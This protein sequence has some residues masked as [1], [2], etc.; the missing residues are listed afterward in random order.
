ML[1]GDCAAAVATLQARG[2][3]PIDLLFIDHLKSLYVPDFVR[4]R[5]A[6]LLAKVGW[7]SF[8]PAGRPMWN[9]CTAGVAASY[10]ALAP[11]RPV[12]RDMWIGSVDLGKL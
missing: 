8:H 10:C 1:V 4:L 5:E 7:V 9:C 3:P 6:G 11:S 2:A 12:F